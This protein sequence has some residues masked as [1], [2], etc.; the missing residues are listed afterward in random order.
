MHVYKKA[1]HSGI[2]TPSSRSFQQGRP[3]AAAMV[4]VACKRAAK[5]TGA[6]KLI[7]TK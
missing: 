7:S 1:E 4:A 6:L 2:G 5:R 3:A